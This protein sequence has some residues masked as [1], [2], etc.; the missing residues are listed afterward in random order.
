[1]LSRLTDKGAETVKVNPSRIKAVDKETGVLGDLEALANARDQD[2]GTLT[3]LLARLDMSMIVTKQLWNL[4]PTDLA[5]S[6]DAVHIW[7]VALDP[8]PP[9]VRS[10]YRTLAADERDRA[11][12]FRSP[13][14]RNRFIVAHGLLRCIL[15]RYLNT[16]PGQLRF[17]YG[18]CG[19]PSLAPPQSQLDLR[20][21]VSHSRGMAL[22][23]V[24]CGREIGVDIEYIR[25]RSSWQRIVRRCLSE[26]EQAA[27]YALPARAQRTAFWRCWTRKEAYLKAIGSGFTYPMDQVSVGVGPDAPAALIQTNADLQYSSDWSIQDLAPGPGYMGAIAVEGRDWHLRCWQWA[28][29]MPDGPLNAC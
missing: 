10:L 14:S 23:A 3:L 19:K 28:E 15:G 26:S 21:S 5:L 22:Y 29:H 16:D 1:M 11:K 6:D 17:W 8:L 2:E 9:S 24:T 20:F 7:R 27:L 25:S 18:R 13:R 4:P 12:R